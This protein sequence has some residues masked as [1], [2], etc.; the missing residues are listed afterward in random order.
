MPIP[1][2]VVERKREAILLQG[3]LP[4]PANPP[5]GCRFHTRCPFVQPTRC[6]DEVPALRTMAAG[7]L[8][9]CHWVEQIEAGKIVRVKHQ[10]AS[11]PPPAE[12]LD[13]PDA[14]PVQE[15]DA[16]RSRSRRDFRKRRK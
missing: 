2:P 6:A 9:A 7:H 4:S 15:F 13:A 14:T 1:D 10:V 5:S 3:D 16:V 11:E 12:T 8:V